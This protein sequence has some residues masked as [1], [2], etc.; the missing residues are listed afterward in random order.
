[1]T[2]GPLSPVMLIASSGL[3]DNQGLDIS[4]NLVPDIDEYETLPVIS[5]FEGVLAN[6][7]AAGNTVIKDDTAQSL[8]NLGAAVFPALTDS[9]PVAQGNTPVGQFT[10]RVASRA[11]TIMGDGDLTRF[12][13]IYGTCR[14]YQAS[15]NQ[16][17]GST[18]NIGAAAAT[19]IDMDAITTGGISLVSADIPTLAQDLRTLGVTINPADMANL[20]FPSALVRQ[21]LDVAGL[22]PALQTQLLANGVSDDVIAEIAES[23]VPLAG[24]TERLIY[25][26]MREVQG[27]TL[28]Q[29]LQ[30]LDVGQLDLSR[31]SDLLDPSLIFP[32]SFRDLLVLVGRDPVNIYRTDGSVNSDLSVQFATEDAFVLLQ[33]ILPPDQALANRALSRSFYQVKN[34]TALTLP[35]I[36]TAAEAVESNQG[37]ADINDLT[38]PVPAQDATAVKS[39]LAPDDAATGAGGLFTLYDFIGTA[40]GYPYVT[41]LP[42]VTQQL[43]NVAEQSGFTPL[44]DPA[45]G[46]YTIMEQTLAGDYGDP[47]TGPIANVPAPFNTGDPYSNADVAFQT[48]ISITQGILGNIANTYVEQATAADDAWEIMVEQYDRE[49]AN[50]QLANLEVDELVGNNRAAIMS[51]ITDL[52]AIGTDVAPKGAAEFFQ[53]VANQATPAG[54][55]VIASLREGRNI[56]ALQNAGIGIDTNLPAA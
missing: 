28:Q 13:Q 9:F 32:A 44:L 30:L 55:A 15:A 36:A 39:A 51:V 12:A 5:S 41:E 35:D 6:V 31:M 54:Q 48:Y 11:N 27:D 38:E 17:I 24:A 52:H 34:L 19:F 49:A 22:L 4:A 53:A 47:T 7:A 8:R 50:W 33:K 2:S 42:E 16:F 18:N 40:A 14:G 26:V 45:N 20:G 21:T 23:A 56:D 25:A 1:M 3:L 46:A 10:G 37:L 43:G 29:V